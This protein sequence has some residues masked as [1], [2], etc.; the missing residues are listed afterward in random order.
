[1]RNR[2]G[3]LFYLIEFSGL[4]QQ[5]IIEY[6]EDNLDN[7][8]YISEMVSISGLFE[9]FNFDLLA[10]LVE[11]SNR[12]QESPRSCMA[13]LNAKPEFGGNLSYNV[14]MKVNGV[15]IPPT[16]ISPN[17]VTLNTSTQDAEMNVYF[18]IKRDK[19][20]EDQDRFDKI[21]SAI[22]PGDG[23]EYDWDFLFQEIQGST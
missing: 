19:D 2:P 1:M 6:C 13:I 16:A 10:S 11:E 21:Y 5:F 23:G 3:R 12:Y 9:S 22:N 15:R 17:T 4:S 8:E 14:N 18:V 20:G 7:K